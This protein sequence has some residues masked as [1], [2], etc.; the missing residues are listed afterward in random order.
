MLRHKEVLEDPGIVEREDGCDEDDMH[1]LSPILL[2]H[3]R[4]MMKPFAL[5]QD[6]GFYAGVCVTPDYVA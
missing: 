6:I 4:P 2:A 5:V 1:R 3:K